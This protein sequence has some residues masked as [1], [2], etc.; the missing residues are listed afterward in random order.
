M[1]HTATQ[2]GATPLIAPM[3]AACIGRLAM[4]MDPAGAPFALLKGEP[5][6]A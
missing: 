4:V 2:L 6:T 3:D 5:K 1:Y